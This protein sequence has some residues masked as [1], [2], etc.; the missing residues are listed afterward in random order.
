MNKM[1]NKLNNV[2]ELIGGRKGVIV[3][4]AEHFR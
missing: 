2:K 4:A 1:D 3:G